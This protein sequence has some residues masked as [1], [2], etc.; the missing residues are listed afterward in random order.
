MSDAAGVDNR[1]VG[2]LPELRVAVGEQAL[3]DR[4]RVGIRDLAAQEAHRETRHGA[5]TLLLALKQVRGPP[6]GHAPVFQPELPQLWPPRFEVAGSDHGGGRRARTKLAHEGLGDVGDHELGLREPFLKRI[7]Q[8]KVERDAVRRGVAS[9]RLDRDRIVVDGEHRPEAEPGRRDRDHS[10]PAAHIGQALRRKLPEQLEAEPR[11]GVSPGAERAAGI[12][13]D[14]LRVS[15]SGLPRRADPELADPNRPVKIAPAI[16]P[17]RG[18]VSGRDRAEGSPEALLAAG[19]GVRRELDAVRK[20]SLLEPLR[21][22]LEHDGARDLGAA[23]RDDRGDAPERPQRKALFSLSKNPSSSR[24]CSSSTVPSSRSRRLR[25]S[26]VS[27]RGTRTFTSTR[28]SPRPNPCS[29]GIPRLRSSRISPGCVPGSKRSS[30]SPSSVGTWRV[31]PSA[32]WV[33]VRS[34]VD[35]MSFPSRTKRGSGRTRIWT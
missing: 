10:G 11:G 17:A 7:G 35:T 3:A 6:F 20:V 22:E 9:G 31:A 29:T 14:R 28:W 26:S 13:H 24:Y 15:R 21:E 2:V 16:L 5:G 18:N 4:L 33:I 23:G 19:V 25:C 34:I 30:T 12:D 1:D 32:A 27:R 8:A